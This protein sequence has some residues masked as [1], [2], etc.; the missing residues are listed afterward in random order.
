MASIPAVMQEIARKGYNMRVKLPSTHIGKIVKGLPLEEA[1]TRV[2]DTAHT[3]T[4]AAAALRQQM[5]INLD[6]PKKIS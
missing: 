1:V 6:F 5:L 2:V 4:K 3:A